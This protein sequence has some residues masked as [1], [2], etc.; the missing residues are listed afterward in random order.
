M[1]L[2][3]LSLN[4]NNRELTSPRLDNSVSWPVRE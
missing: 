4:A 3:I 2:L 1:K